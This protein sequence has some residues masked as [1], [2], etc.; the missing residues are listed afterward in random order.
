MGSPGPGVG[1]DAKLYYRSGGTYALPT[2]SLIERIGD[3][4]LG[5]EKSTSDLAI[6]ETPNDKSSFGGLKFPISFTYYK[7][8]LVE[9]VVFTALQDSFLN[10]T[11]LDIA[12]VDQ[13][14]ATVG[15]AGF[16]GPYVVSKF[17]RSEPVNDSIS[18]S[19]ELLECEDVDGTTPLYM[20]AYT[21]SGP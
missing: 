4:T 7:R 11:P 14:I 6:R 18:Y 20:K 13:A 10:N 15:A 2:W 16:R 8:N 19:V 5:A 3:V 21:T 17:E 12:A 9:D 1:R